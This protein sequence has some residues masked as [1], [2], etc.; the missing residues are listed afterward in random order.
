MTIPSRDYFIVFDKS[1]VK[2]NE[3][4]YE[5]NFFYLKSY[6]QITS[7][8][9][10]LK[11]PFFRGNILFGLDFKNKVRPLSFSKIQNDG[12]MTPV[13]PRLFKKFLLS[14]KN[15]F[16]AFSNQTEPQEFLPIRKMLENFQFNK[17][18][19]IN[20]TFCKSCLENKKFN[21]LTKNSQIKAINNQILCPECALN[22]VIKRAKNIGLISGEKLSPKL[23]NF[24]THMILKFK[25]V[26]K[27]LSSF[28][29]D[30]D[31][32]RNKELTLYDVEVTPTVNKKYL[33][34]NIDDLLIPNQ[35]KDVLKEQNIKTLLPIQAISIDKGLISEKKD[36]LI[37]APTSA[38]KTLVGE[39][40]GITR[41]ISDNYKMLYLVPIVALANVRTDEFQRKYSNLKLKIIKKIGISLLETEQEGNIDDLIDADV[42]IGTYEAIDF[43]MRSANKDKLGKIG[44]IVI[45]EIQTLIDPERG[46][47]LDGLI[48]RLK[49][50]FKEAQFL[51]LSATIGAPDLLAK[52]LG[53]ILIRY[54]NR[55][56]PIE[57]HLILC[58]N[59]TIKHKYIVKL[60][61]SAFLQKSNYGF[62]GQSIIFSNTRKKCENLANYL[63]KKNINTKAYHSGLTNDERKEIESEFQLQKIAAVV[64]TAA[65]A[66]GVDFPAKQVIFESLGM[67]IKILTV[68]EF[69]QMLGRAGRLKK[70]EEGIV[71]ILAEPG[72]IYSPKM[73]L[74]EENIAINLL[75]GKIKDF[76]L[77]PDG[78]RSLTELLAFISIYREGIDLSKIYNFYEYLINATYEIDVFL[79]DLTKYKL[80][81]RNNDSYYRSTELGRS[82]AKSFLTVD[83]ALEIIN[84]LKIKSINLMDLVLDLKP[85]KNVYLSKKVIADLSKNISMK[86]FSNNFFSASVLSLMDAEYVKKRK[87]F[88]QDF[89]ELILKWINDI[90]NCQCKDNPYC[91]C[92]RLN[93]EYLILK[94]RINERLS[95]EQISNYL[96]ENYEIMVFKGDLIDYFE[97]LIYSYESILNISKGM[98]NL[99]DPEYKKE[100]SE[101]PQII[102]R[103]KNP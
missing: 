22:I 93:L 40:A 100:L 65:L 90:F 95:I 54:N 49:T 34:L 62:K 88:S 24:F 42:I 21:I 70:H 27:A 89:I 45:D 74:T 8:F 47:I 71:Y 75:N 48:S 23:K 52:K 57:R 82:I 36:Q 29:I 99:L 33:N 43:I 66:A 79:K 56:V 32:V 63:Q 20:L 39:L 68:A 53:S 2:K 64:A 61:R 94:L 9:S 25:S 85:L 16:I 35:F 76:E 19:F 51:Y 12:S 18:R 103:I 58:L 11:K 50:I 72:K 14:E 84:K 13:N 26:E 78:D 38:G 31:P 5:I 97:N 96:K 86:Y 67:G 98:E 30:F 1:L 80:I 59:E 92:G 46:F 7:K 44:T 55:P 69:E 101:I 60:V 73:K 15:R 37:M 3:L 6:N 91:E 83:E 87:R 28:K 10:Y 4:Q 17:E 102:Q 81:E 77:E 41:I